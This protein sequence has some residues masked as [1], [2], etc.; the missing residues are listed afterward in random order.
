MSRLF[1]LLAAMLLALGMLA[2]PALANQGQGGGPSLEGGNWLAGVATPVELE[3]GDVLLRDLSLNG[4]YDYVEVRHNIAET[5][6][7]YTTL[8]QREPNRIGGQN[9]VTHNPTNYNEAWLSILGPEGPG[10]HHKGTFSWYYEVD[11]NEWVSLKF[12]FNGKGE[13]LN[14]NGVA[15]Q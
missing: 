11:D 7:G 12:Q 6:A 9:R 2:G 3:P 10:V 13:L 1:T 8:V 15:P 4:T 5:Y 14:V